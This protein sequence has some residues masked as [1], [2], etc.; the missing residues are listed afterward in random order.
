MVDAIRPITG[1]SATSPTQVGRSLSIT[2]EPDNKWVAT[3]QSI[4]DSDQVALK[5]ANAELQAD[6]ARYSGVADD[7]ME[8]SPDHHS[9]GG[10][11]TEREGLGVADKDE[12]EKLSG[13]SDLIGTVDFDDD[14]PFGHRTAIV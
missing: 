6:M 11:D 8:V 7:E 10:S 1:S 5:Q 3:R 2:S 4:I 12:K 9:H 14:T 13:E